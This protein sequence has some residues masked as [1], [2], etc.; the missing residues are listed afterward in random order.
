LDTAEIHMPTAL[1][2]LRKPETWKAAAKDLFSERLVSVRKQDITL[3]AL[4]G[5]A[6]GAAIV[7]IIT[8]LILRHS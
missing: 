4:E 8:T 5:A 3:V 7:A 2:Q 6:A 1:L